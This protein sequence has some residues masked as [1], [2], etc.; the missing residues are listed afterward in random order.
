MVS[1]E[2]SWVGKN[3]SIARLIGIGTLFVGKK[4]MADLAPRAAL[5]GPQ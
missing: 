4:K 1:T 2:V 3:R 5:R